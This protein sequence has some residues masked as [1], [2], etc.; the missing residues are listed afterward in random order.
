ML[1]P[2]DWIL[3]PR[4]ASSRAGAAHLK[5]VFR[6]VKVSVRGAQIVV[7]LRPLQLPREVDVTNFCFRVEL[8]HFPSTFPVPVP[9]LFDPTEWEMCL[10]ADG[11]RVDVRDAVVELL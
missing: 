5:D 11:R 9:C 7:D 4:P 6:P 3:W 2:S 8:V 1:R 10:C